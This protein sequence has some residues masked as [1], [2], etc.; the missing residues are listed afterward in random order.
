MDDQTALQIGRILKSGEAHL[1]PHVRTRLIQ[2]RAAAL[3]HPGRALA[4]TGRSSLVLIEVLPAVRMIV[5]GLAL[6]TGVFASYT[7]NQYRKAGEYAAIDSALLA[8]DL[9][10]EAYLD[11]GFEAWLQFA[12]SG[13][14]AN[15]H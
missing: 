15:G 5:I 8:D 10:P 12:S 4:T 11:D 1:T 3:R 13:L 9:P 7:W 14:P 2:I 6:L